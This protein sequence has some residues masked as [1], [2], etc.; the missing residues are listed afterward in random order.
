MILHCNFEEL[1]ALASA[2]EVLVAEAHART[3]G[4]AAPPEGVVMVESLIPRLTGDMS[5][6]TLDDQRRVQGAVTV[7]VD[8][9]RRRMD[10]QIIETT[11]GN[12]EALNL[13][14]D[15]GHS[16]SVL[17]RLDQMG[18]EMAAIVE[19][20]AGGNPAGVTFPD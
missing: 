10:H 15:Y 4:V 1:R 5:I 7:L 2:G 16:R 11:P 20:I 3:G 6:E 12:E 9:L 17:H 8:D 18:A 14:F 19:L 13:Y